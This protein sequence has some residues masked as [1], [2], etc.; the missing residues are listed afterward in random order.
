MIIAPLSAAVCI[1]RRI[2]A[3][4][5]VEHPRVGHEQLE[6][7]DALV[8]DELVHRLE[9]VVVDAA[10]DHVEAVVDRAVA[11]GLGVPR[12][13]A[14]LHHA[15][16]SRCTAKSMIVVVPPQAAARVPVSKVS[17]ANVPPNGSS[18]CVCASTPPGIDVLARSRR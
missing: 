6:A 5:A 18:M 8:V 9:R 4:V 12:V 14:V 2:C 17:D 1:A 16:R 7:G 11:V 15:R 13:E 3:V 10:E